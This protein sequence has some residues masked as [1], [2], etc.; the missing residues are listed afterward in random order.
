ME[1][2]M[3]EMDMYNDYVKTEQINPEYK[4]TILKD[5]TDYSSK[6]EMFK[7]INNT[8]NPITENELKSGLMKCKQFK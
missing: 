8:K 3:I 1:L 5:Y 2:F 7:L 6:S 4:K